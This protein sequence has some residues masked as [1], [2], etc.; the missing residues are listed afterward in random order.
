MPDKVKPGTAAAERGL[1]GLDPGLQISPTHTADVSGTQATPRGRAGPVIRAE[2]VGADQCHAEGHRV[3][4]AAPVLAIC[5]KLIAAGLNPDRP[6][7]AYRNTNLCLVIRCIGEAAQFVVDKRRM[8]LAHWKPLSCAEVS[9]RIAPFEPAASS[10]P[11][12]GAP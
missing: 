10:T 11:A 5:R 7:H 12:G 6:L 8:A 2:I 4:G 9:P 1:R 3:R